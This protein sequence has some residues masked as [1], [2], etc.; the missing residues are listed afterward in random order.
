MNTPVTFSGPAA[1]DDLL[2]T[3]NGN[4]PK[5]T[6]NNCGCGVTPWGTYL[7]CEE[8]FQGYFGT[9]DSEW[10]ATPRQERYG[11]SSSGFGY[12]WHLFDRRFDLANAGYANEE[13]RFGWVV[14]IDP[15]DARQTPVKRT[16]LGRF[17]HESAA[18]TVGK[19]RRVVVYMGDDQ[20]FDYVYKFVGDD[21]YFKNLN[22]D[23]SPF[24][25][26]QTLCC[27]IQR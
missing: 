23:E 4:L 21:D 27:E 17:K 8:N 10:S 16:G 22:D 11:F 7:T 19:D 26:G 3:D 5:G 24:D 9:E 6:L 12:G 13:N 1:A 18:V 2:V 15:Y 20:T 14:E 25:H